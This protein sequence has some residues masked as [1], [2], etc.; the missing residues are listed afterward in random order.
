M[1]RI[2]TVLTKRLTSELMAQHPGAF[3]K[4]YEENKILVNKHTNVTSKKIRNAVA[5]FLTR[6]TKHSS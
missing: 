1:G 5:G 3:K 4:N 2:K 6:R